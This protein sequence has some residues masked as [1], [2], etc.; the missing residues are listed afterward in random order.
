[1]TMDG[2]K[3]FGSTVNEPSGNSWGC[4]DD[5]LRVIYESIADLNLQL[6][7][8][9][10]MEQS[11]STVLFGGGSRLDSLGLGNFIVIAEQKLEERFGFRF[12]LTEDDPFSPAT[13]HFR[14]VQS[15]AT[16]VCELA[17]KRVPRALQQ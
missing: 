14:T 3:T 12:D 8:D 13:G 2:I 16:Y 5:V 7:Q 6:P 4:F 11:A 1:M 10:R 15:L 17:E 9:R